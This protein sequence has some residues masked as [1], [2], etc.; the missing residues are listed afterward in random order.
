[1]SRPRCNVLILQRFAIICSVFSKC[2]RMLRWTQ[3]APRARA[4]CGRK[5]R[6]IV[7]EHPSMTSAEDRYHED[8]FYRLNVFPIEVPHLRERREDIPLLVNYFVSK[9]SRRMGKKIR[10]SRSKRCRCWRT[11]GGRQ[12]ARAAKLHRARSHSHTGQRV[13]CASRGAGARCKRLS[14][15]PCSPFTT[16][17]GGPSLMHSRLL[18][19]NLPARAARGRTPRSETHYASEQDAAA[20]YLASGLLA[21]TGAGAEPCAA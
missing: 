13:V 3:A 11:P 19:A 16:P 18:Q 6:E 7:V 5:P 2:S 15:T 12:R 10:P 17:S 8:L 4:R 1:M 21:V 20:Q 14:P 9:L